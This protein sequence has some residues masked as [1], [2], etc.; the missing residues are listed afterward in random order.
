MRPVRIRLASE[1][2]CQMSATSLMGRRVTGR[3]LR[4][5]RGRGDST[6]TWGLVTGPGAGAS[7]RPRDRTVLSAD[8]FGR[9][10]RSCLNYDAE[11]GRRVQRLWEGSH[12]GLV[13]RS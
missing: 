6:V 11:S 4:G 8:P 7:A 5:G 2:S 3:G 1:R 10:R 13:R 9:R 12:S